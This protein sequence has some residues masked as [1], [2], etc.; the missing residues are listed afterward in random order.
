[1]KTID[2]KT[3]LFNL[4]LLYISYFK[5]FDGIKK[6]NKLLYFTDFEYYEKFSKSIT[7]YNYIKYQRGPVIENYSEII[8]EMENNKLVRRGK[9]EVL[10]LN[11]IYTVSRIKNMVEPDLDLFEKEELEVIRYVLSNNLV[12]YPPL[13]TVACKSHS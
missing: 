5:D 12:N 8:K 7:G 11:K 13:K 3:K 1:M 4:I 2:N 6:L 9:K 10:G